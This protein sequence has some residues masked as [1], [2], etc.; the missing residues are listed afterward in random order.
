MANS[1]RI[2]VR[3]EA[4]GLQARTNDEGV[5]VVSDDTGA[6]KYMID[7]RKGPRFVQIIVFCPDSMLLAV[8]GT[9]WSNGSF[10]STIHV[11][12][13]DRRND[14]ISGRPIQRIPSPGRSVFAIAMAPDNKTI[15]VSDEDGVRFWQVGSQSPFR[16]FTPHY[17]KKWDKSIVA[18]CVAVSADMRWLATWGY[19]SIK[20]WDYRSLQPLRAIA[21]GEDVGCALAFSPDSSTL[22][23]VGRHTVTRWR[24]TP[25]IWPFL[26][27]GG[28]ALAGA[29]VMVGTCGTR[30]RKRAEPCSRA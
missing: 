20:L 27:A 4:T 25:S 22:I 26:L 16:E 28:V 11:W 15:V 9:E 29:A 3:S 12:Q 6:S 2:G 10:G 23:A 30:R 7:L 8:S 5:V 24:V 14:Q 13:I 17:S 19:G 18:D 1:D 21:A